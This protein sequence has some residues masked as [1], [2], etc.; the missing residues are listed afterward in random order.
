MPDGCK[1][2]YESIGTCFGPSDFTKHWKLHFRPP[3]FNSGYENW[4]SKPFFSSR[5]LS[6][7]LWDSGFLLLGL[8]LRILNYE[9]WIMVSP[10]HP[11]LGPPG[12]PIPTPASD[13][14][15]SHHIPN[16]TAGQ[17]RTFAWGQGKRNYSGKRKTGVHEAIRTLFLALSPTHGRV[18]LTNSTKR[19]SLEQSWCRRR[20][21]R[22]QILV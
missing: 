19:T 16:T 7:D 2:S 8:A 20:Q 18:N 10:K 4:S 3:N 22:D 1:T 15:Q 14:R 12:I 6:G 21:D 11:S 13:R 5:S 17:L 9:L